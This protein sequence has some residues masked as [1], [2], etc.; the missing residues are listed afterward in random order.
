MIPFLENHYGNPSALHPEGIGA[1]QAV[2]HARN[3]VATLLKCK[4][5]ETIFT[6]GASESNNN[7]LKGVFQ[8]LKEKENHIITTKIQ[9][10]SIIKPCEYLEK[11]TGTVSSRFL[12]FYQLDKVREGY[13]FRL[14]VSP[15]C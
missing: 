15:P 5:S 12:N 13:L 6:S 11:N 3:Q 1:K 14:W 2:E 7:V 8:G 10:S 4:P 9:H